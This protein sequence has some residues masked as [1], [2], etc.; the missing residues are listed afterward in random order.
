MTSQRR[1]RT[2]EPADV[3]RRGANA[4]EDP[5]KAEVLELMHTAE[6]RSLMT[7]DAQ[8][9][10]F[11]DKQHC[12]KWD[13]I[14]RV[15]QKPESTVR[16]WINPRGKPKSDDEIPES[17]DDEFQNSHSFLT[18][19]EEKRVCQW[20][21]DRQRKKQCPSSVEVR[22][23]AASLRNDR[24]HDEI[25][26]SRHWWASFKAR[27]P[28]LDV[29]VLG[30]TESARCEVPAEAVRAY[31]AEVEHALSAIRVPDQMLNMDETG[32][33]SR[34]MKAKKRAIVYSKKCAT[35]A[36]FREEKDLNHVTLVATIN[37]LGQRLKPLYLITNKVTIRDPEL[38][39]MS[40]GLALY[41]TTKGYQNRHSMQFYIQ[42]VLAPYCENLRNIM[43]DPALPVFLIMDNCSCHNKPELLGLYASHNIHIIWLPPH[44]SH[45]LQPLD[46]GLFGEL[47]RR[48]QRS[49][50]KVTKPQWQGKV[51]R[52]D[53]SW[54]GSTYALTVW[55]SW[56]AAGI[57][58]CTSAIPRWH[59]DQD[60]IEAKI[61]EHCRWQELT[62]ANQ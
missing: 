58:P 22:E 7:N 13:T 27:H 4:L 61:T 53:R 54:H 17:Q 52:I 59:V 45:F 28:D 26:C 20:I 14:A 48:Y 49:S 55:K 43:R 47:K 19:G 37:L 38:H 21:I 11:R 62:G 8:V 42:E 5:E 24:T 15:F 50:R 1:A 31:V 25:E 29:E 60:E 3:L 30:A 36:A 44:S 40:S 10:F 9:E 41:E 32:F 51:L 16:G 33:C 2:P 56:A 57:R 6:F 18:I 35:K 12:F 39:L 34:P 23:F 46:L